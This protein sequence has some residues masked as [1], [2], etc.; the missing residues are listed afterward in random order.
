MATAKFVSKS[1]KPHE[2]R[3]AFTGGFTENDQAAI[4][5]HMTE[6]SQRGRKGLGFTD[7]DQGF[8]LYILIRIRKSLKC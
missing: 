2:G 3:A 5:E 6:I 1:K 8:V 4:A 7:N